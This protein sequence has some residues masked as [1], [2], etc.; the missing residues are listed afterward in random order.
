M[1]SGPENNA[2]DKNHE[3][4][5]FRIEVEVAQKRKG[6]WSVMKATTPEAA[7]V[8]RDLMYFV[9]LLDDRSITKMPQPST[10]PPTSKKPFLSKYTTVFLLMYSSI[11]IRDRHRL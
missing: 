5:V 10:L 6:H 11:L 8:A 1:L 4:S 7:S 9:I 3:D 2:K